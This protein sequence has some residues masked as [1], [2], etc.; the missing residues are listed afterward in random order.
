MIKTAVAG[1]RLCGSDVRSDGHRIHED[2][3]PIKK[4]VMATW[5]AITVAS[6]SRLIPAGRA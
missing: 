2:G 5:A 3:A 4:L 6:P 1:N